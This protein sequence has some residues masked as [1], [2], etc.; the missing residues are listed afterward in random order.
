MAKPKPMAMG[1]LPVERLTPYVRPFTYTGLDFFGPVSV[2]IGRRHEK[3]WVALFTCLT[4]RAVH[5]E[6]AA[7]LSTDACIICI[8]NFCN[9]R[10]TPKQIRSDNGTNFVGANNEIRRLDDF[11]D[12]GAILRETATKG[13][14]WIFNCPSNPEAGGAW[15]RLVQSAKRVLKITLKEASPKVETLRSLLLEAANILN[16]RPLTHVP[17]DPS[18]SEPLTPNHFLVG[19]TNSTTAVGP[20][21][22]C[23][24]KQWRICQQLT[25]CFWNRWVRDYLP[26]LTR[27]SKH[28]GESPN[29]KENDLVIICESNQSRNQWKRGRI[30]RT[31][32]GTDGRVRVADVLTADGVLRRPA[33][34]LAVLDVSL[35]ANGARDVDAAT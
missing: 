12:T 31:L 22:S 13:I 24:R 26:E 20:G 19:H 6:V 10:G 29:L 23:S 27:R 21:E 15:E 7:D 30:I 25:H 11:L 14:D 5:L 3:R 28:Y 2:S 9:L 8:R 35:P 18:D 34:K 1:Q 32:P 16:S 4:I 17:V 33:T